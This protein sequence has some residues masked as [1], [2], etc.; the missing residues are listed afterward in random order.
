MPRLGE[1][2]AEEL[3]DVAGMD[4]CHASSKSSASRRQIDEDF[5]AIYLPRRANE[6]T[7][8]DKAPDDAVARTV[9]DEEP[10]GQVTHAYWFAVEV[11]LMNDVV[12][13]E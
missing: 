8:T 6:V 13:V 4:N 3:F 5:T 12:V 2:G 9:G 11:D 1:W 10:L 7:S